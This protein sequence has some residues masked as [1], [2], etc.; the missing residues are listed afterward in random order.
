M[1]VLRRPGARLRQKE[2]SR[3]SSAGRSAR[4]AG[5]SRSRVWPR[6]SRPS[7]CAYQEKGPQNLTSCQGVPSTLM[8]AVPDSKKAGRIAIKHFLDSLCW[9][10]MTPDKP[11]LQADAGMLTKVAAVGHLKGCFVRN[12][13][14]KIVEAH[15]RE[16]RPGGRKLHQ[17]LAAHGERH[18]PVDVVAVDRQLLQPPQAPQHAQPLRP[19]CTSLPQ[20]LP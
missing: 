18:P 19:P 2:T 16:V 15:V 11:L 3:R 14:T 4:N 10:R 1:R 17:A 7:S 6:S 13:D 8:V 12:R 5:S 9:I 20:E